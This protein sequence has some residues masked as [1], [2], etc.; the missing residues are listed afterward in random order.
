MSSSISTSTGRPPT[1]PPVCSSPR[2]KP[3]RI[4]A[5]STPPGPESVLMKPIFTLSAAWAGKASAA[6]KAAATAA[7]SSVDL[8]RMGF[9]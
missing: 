9:L 6:E 5:P 4:A 2:L 3:S 1:L 8:M 7:A